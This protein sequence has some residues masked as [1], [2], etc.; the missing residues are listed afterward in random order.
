MINDDH[1]GTQGTNLS[2]CRSRA[3]AFFL[4]QENSDDEMEGGLG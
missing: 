1:Y 2:R 3:A 4:P